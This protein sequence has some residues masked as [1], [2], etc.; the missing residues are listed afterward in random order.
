VYAGLSTAG[1][2]IKGRKFILPCASFLCLDSGLYSS[3]LTRGWQHGPLC[4]LLF[5]CVGIW[6]FLL[7]IGC[8]FLSKQ[9]CVLS[10]L[11]DFWFRIQIR[12]CWQSQ[13]CPTLAAYQRVEEEKVFRRLLC[14]YDAL[15]IGNCW[16]FWGA[17]CLHRQV[18]WERASCVEEMVTFDMD[19]FIREAMKIELHFS[20]V[21]TEVTS[22]TVLGHLTF[23]PW[24]HRKLSLWGLRPW[25]THTV[26]PTSSLH[27]VIYLTLCQMLISLTY[28]FLLYF[29]YFVPMTLPTP[30]HKFYPWLPTPYHRS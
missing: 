6:N 23:T 18:S 19:W 22:W 25:P 8:L 10:C 29:L 24:G 20:S 15:L 17:C 30:Y 12:D 28:L 7:L 26:C 4:Q 27:L 21:N 2:K 3:S 1:F 16:H 5:F 14:G 13:V 11:A 9:R